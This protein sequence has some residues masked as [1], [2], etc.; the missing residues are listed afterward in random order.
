VPKDIPKFGKSEHKDIEDF[1]LGFE[2]VLNT[3]KLEYD[4]NWEHLLP[5]GLQQ[6]ES[7]WVEANLAHKQF[8]WKEAKTL[9]VKHYTQPMGL[10]KR[11]QSL[12][13]GN[14]KD[15]QNICAFCDE[16]VQIMRDCNVKDD[17]MLL[18]EAFV[19]CFPNNKGQKVLEQERRFRLQ[20]HRRLLWQLK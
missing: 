6:L 13:M 1:V 17:N 5:L 10:S 14:V 8:T 16:F 2:K 20:A 18:T 12:F 19:C 9:L 7:Q 3:Y 11:L 15:M 4:A